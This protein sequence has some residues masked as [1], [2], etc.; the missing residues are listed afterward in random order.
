MDENL[1]PERDAIER[2]R[3]MYW[4][5]GVRL[6]LDVPTAYAVEHIIEPEGFQRNKAGAHFRRNK[7]GRYQHGRHTPRATLVAR[8]A[9]FVP[10]SPKEINH[11]LWKALSETPNIA[12][13]AP[14]WLRQLT[15]GLQLLVF[16]DDDQLRATV[17]RPVLAKIER[18]ASL[19]SLACL[20]ILWKRYFAIGELEQAWRVAT[21]VFRVLLMV[22]AEFS[23]RG[24]G[25]TIFAVF[26]E[27]IF[28]KASWNGER[29]YL[30][31]YDYSFSSEFLDQVAMRCLSDKGLE[32][33]WSKKVQQMIGILDG[34]IGIG[35]RFA[36]WPTVGPDDNLGPLSEKMR[37]TLDS[38]F[39]IRRRSMEK[40]IA[41]NTFD[42]L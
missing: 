31:G 38:N 2:I 26:V 17:D 29:F 22:G 27:K 23:K 21:S 3:T 13:E 19:D 39:R 5:E 34:K 30:E 42:H 8:T 4:F 15:P 24:V 37:R 10:G 32:Q 7:W 41:G 6:H 18:L 36:L 14:I 20:T 40:I 9:E 28:E 1:A 35:I 11:V 16:T 25:D 12:R 33:S